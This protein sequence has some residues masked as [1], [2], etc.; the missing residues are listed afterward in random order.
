[1]DIECFKCHELVDDDEHIAGCCFSC[2]YGEDNA[3]EPTY[4]ELEY[5]LREREEE[6][7]RY[8]SILAEY[9]V[10]NYK[11]FKQVQMYKQQ[12]QNLTFNPSDLFAKMTIIYPEGEEFDIPK[13]KK[14]NTTR[15][16]N[17]IYYD[18]GRP[19][20]DGK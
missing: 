20:D 14:Y 12:I 10:E 7:K 8:H 2:Y 9:Q 11:L 4:E 6:L 3:P 18:F 19:V 1:M 17:V 5:K 13:E 15:E 16:K